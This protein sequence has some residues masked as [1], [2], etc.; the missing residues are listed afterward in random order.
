MKV[1]DRT[2]TDKL[3]T[4]HNYI[5]VLDSIALKTHRCNT[6]E[7]LKMEMG[8]ASTVAHLDLLL[9]VTMCNQIRTPNHQIR[10]EIFCISSR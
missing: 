6:L 8:V 2:Q 9:K 10:G 1:N 4:D 7:T 3:L 5:Y